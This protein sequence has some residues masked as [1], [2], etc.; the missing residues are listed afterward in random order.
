MPNPT[1]TIETIVKTAA[2]T[3]AAPL[4]LP[5]TLLKPKRA[6]TVGAVTGRTGRGQVLASRGVAGGCGI[7]GKR[8]GCPAHGEAEQNHYFLHNCS[9]P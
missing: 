4:T 5:L 3:A 9:S 8:A 6:V 2:K 1:D 7:G